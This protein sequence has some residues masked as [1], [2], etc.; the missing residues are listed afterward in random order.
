MA[1]SIRSPTLQ[2]ALELLQIND[3]DGKMV[4]QYQTRGILPADLLK[5][6][7][8]KE[9][10]MVGISPDEFIK[11]HGS[12]T[13]DF[14][15]LMRDF[16]K[17]CY[18]FNQ[19]LQLDT[20]SYAA[21]FCSKI[22]YEVG[23]QARQVNKKDGDKTWKFAF[24]YQP[25]KVRTR[26]A[27]GTEKD[28]VAGPAIKF[29]FVSTYKADDAEYIQNNDGTKIVLSIKNASLLALMTLA[30]LN[31]ISINSTP[32]IM[33]LTPLAGAVFSRDDISEIARLLNKGELEVLNCINESCQS[34]GHYL[35]YSSL[36]CAA[37]ASIVA[38][39]NMKDEKMRHGII[40]KTMKQYLG[41][42]KQWNAN[43]FD[44]FAQYGH[45]GVPSNISPD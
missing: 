18:D 16:K 9:Y 15:Q 27:D 41:K 31:A 24:V 23:P 3:A 21:E 30:R 7:V 20:P 5:H 28:A 34:G 11:I 42:K 14:D 37:V 43:E 12:S 44:I 36:A 22:L 29:A 25:H 45:G 17:V 40:G 33:L 13:M 8:A 6:N 26:D 19:P 32:S 2:G 4:A 1:T 39:R 35:T 38:T 10:I